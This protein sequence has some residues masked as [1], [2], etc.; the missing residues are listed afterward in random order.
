[1][2]CKSCLYAVNG[3]TQSVSDGGLINFGAV[4]RRYG[5]NAYMSGG[6]I[7]ILGSGYYDINTNFTLVA[8][9]AGTATITLMKDGTAISG[10]SASLTVESGS[11]YALAIPAVLRQMCCCESSITAMLSGV[12]G[13]VANATMI[14]EKL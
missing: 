12:T 9:G 1:M 2:S 3:T 5:Q 8:S 13:T 10:A 6:N 4:A 11:T 14:V 7:E